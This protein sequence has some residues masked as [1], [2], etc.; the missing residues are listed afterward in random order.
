MN[1]YS[2]AFNFGAY[3][4]AAVDPRSGQYS[5]RINLMTLCP[6]GPLEVSRNIALSFSMLSADSS[7]YGTGW[8]LSNTEFDS[9]RLRLTLLSGEQFKAQSMPIVGGTLVFKDRKLKDLVVRRPDAN[10]LHVV[11][12]DGTVE[13]LQRTDSSMPYRIVAIEFENG[14]RLKWEY[15]RGGSLE[16]VLGHDQQVLLL[17]TYSSGQLAMVDSRVDGGRYA[18]TR[19]TYSNGRLT[20]VTA[21]YDRDGALQS[22]GYVFGY[23][24]AFSN[25]LIGINQVKSPMGGEEFIRYIEKGHQYGNGQY[26]PRVFSWVQTPASSQEPITRTYTYST[27]SNF[28]GFPYSGGFREGEDNL[29][30]IG[31]DYSYWTEEQCIDPLLN[32]TVLSSIRSTYNRFHLLTEERCLR[33]GTLTTTNVAYNIKPGLFAEQPANFQLPHTITKR[34]ELFAGGTSREETQH[35]ET[36]E[37]GNELGRTEASGVRTEFSYYPITGE[38]GRCPA[39]PHDLFQRYVKQEH[40]IPAAPTPAARLTEY[41]YTRVPMTGSSYFVLQE[42]SSQAGVFSMRQ[43]YYETPVELAGRLKSTSNTIDGLSLSSDFS[44]TITGDNL[45][46]N[47]RL[48]GREGQW[49]ESTRTLSLTNRRLLSMSRDG[50]STLDLG[51]DVGGRLTAETVSSGK[52]QQASRRYTYHFATQGKRAHL[53]TTD[54]QDNQVITYFDGLGRQVSEA[55]LIGEDE[56]RV[57]G[58]WLYDALGQTVE[59]V[60]TDY[61]NDGPRSLKSTYS[62]NSWGNASRVA[63]ADGSVLIDEYDPLLNLKSEGVEGAERLKTYF[64]EHN[65]PV[66][67]ERLDA[68]EHGVQVESRTYDGLG[69][70]MSVLD[71][72]NNLTE[73]SYDAFDR[74]MTVHQ[75]P[76]DGTAPRIRKMDYAPGISSESAIALTVDGER[77]GTRTYDSLGRMTSQAHGEGQTTTWEYEAGWMEPIAMVSPRGARQSLV[78]DKELDVPTRIEMTGL[79]VSTYRYDP[80]AGTL[81]RSETNGLIHEFFQDVNGHLEKEL[82]TATG[83]SVTT[84]YGYSPGGRLLH[85]TAADG[86][87]SE[88]E[89]DAQGRFSK[90]TT[91]SMVIEQSYDNLGR[92]QNLTTDYD[93]MQIVTKVSYDAL[94]REAERRFEQNGTLLQ[95]MTCTY[96][97]NSMLA[98]RFL[99]DASSRVVIGETFTYDAYLRLKTYRCEGLEHPQDQMGRGIVGQD[100]SFDSLNNITQVVTS[101]AGGTQDICE[102]FFTGPDPTQLTRLTHTLPVQDVTLTYDAAGNLSVGPS[103]QFY[104]YNEFEQLTDVRTGAFQYSYQYDAESRQVLASRSGEAPVMLAYAGDRLETLVEGNKKIR[105]FTGD[106]QVMA[107]GGGV[108]GPQLHANDAAGSV[109]GLSAPGQAHVRRHYL[110]YGDTKIPLDDGKARTMADLQLPAFNGQ[111]LDAAIRL[112]FLGNGRRAYDPE[113]MMFLQADPLSPFDEGGINSYAYCACNP[114]NLMDPSGLWPS[115]LKWVLTG[116]ALALSLVT[117]GFG[118]PALAGAVAGGATAMAIASKAAILG[119]AA[120]GV[121][122]GTL[123]TAALGVAEVDKAMGWD[124]SNHINNLGWA[125]LAFSVASLAVGIGGAYTSAHMAYKTAAAKFTGVGKLVDTPIGSALMAGRDRMLGLTYKFTDKAGITPYSQAF[126]STRAI[127]RFT[128]LGRSIESRSQAGAKASPEASDGSFS[129]S[130]QAQTQPALIGLKDMPSGSVEYYQAF[131]DEATRVRQPILRELIQ[132]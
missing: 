76:A 3:L 86:Q 40:L 96:H 88:L 120:L 52:A 127:L 75:K 55:Q 49:L 60:N 50:G 130:A 38:S 82:Q 5:V 65:Q 27:G 66:R 53:I 111:R 12:K 99:H 115:W 125:A 83:T 84:L 124:R 16:R 41:T 59:V 33:E 97:V 105:Y 78:Y 44:Y 98:S 126:A 19:F 107:R 119:G 81:A 74:Q 26:L 77:V 6:M 101:F 90:M 122:G 114:I 104:T 95:V 64:N 67:V 103:G 109:R 15:T 116:A 20:A 7:V 32:D 129:A 132:A 112:Y 117:V 17:L 39:D 23:T 94:G 21:P 24:P 13:V 72:N 1:V 8:R 106:D 9:A 61:L 2:Q 22:A 25:G 11:Y 108:D 69:R 121:V 34:Y 93:S 45:V 89:Y 35:I 80:V 30:L 118:A 62:Y 92:P 47:R 79:P 10:T 31:G 87:R 68:S 123:S 85:Q 14:E 113:L 73:F 110:P 18:R 28:T 46:E 128:N 51:F 48:K 102:R 37:Y 56:E 57:T 70:C 131:R 4:N 54:A 91:G 71:V 100:F 29:Y 43:S 58:T 36:D 63:R 42:S